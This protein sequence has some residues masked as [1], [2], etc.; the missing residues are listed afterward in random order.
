MSPEISS[1]SSE[2]V[3]IL[4]I[5]AG[6]PPYQIDA[7][8][9]GLGGEWYINAYHGETNS[10]QPAIGLP[11]LVT[12]GAGVEDQTGSYEDLMAH[13]AAQALSEELGARVT[14]TINLGLR[15]ISAQDAHRL[16]ANLRRLVREV[17]AQL[18]PS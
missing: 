11:I 17:V 18:K 2:H 7:A 13:E 16:R 8:V 14:I 9:I 5:S 10:K 12:G 6:Q 3:R 15:R 4:Q 1:E